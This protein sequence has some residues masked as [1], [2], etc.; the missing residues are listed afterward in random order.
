MRRHVTEQVRLVTQHRDIRD[1]VAAFGEHHR[2]IDQHPTADVA[3]TTL[4]RG[5]HHTD[6]LD[7]SPI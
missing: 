2:D 4:L 1:R 7:V 5:C 3:T 6:K